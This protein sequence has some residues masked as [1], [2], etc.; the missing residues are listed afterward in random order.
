MKQRSKRYY[1][2]I[3]FSRTAKY[4]IDDAIDL[5]QQ[6]VNTKFDA[7]IDI[8]INFDNNIKKTNQNVIGTVIL[9]HGTGKQIK[10]L[11]LTK[12]KIREAQQAGADFVGAEEL[13]DQIQNENWLDFNTIIATP[14]IMKEISKISKILGPKGLMPNVKTNTITVDIVKTINDIRTGRIVYKLDKT[15]NIHC[16]IGKV[17][18][19]KQFLCDNFIALIDEI[20]YLKSNIKNIVVCP[21]M[22]PS[23]K[24]NI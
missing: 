3:I 2:N 17:S 19:N 5:V 15:N 14:D 24:I 7:A 12:T 1:N 23:I 18:F 6:M 16:S 4:D 13:I 21:T 10:I 22:G 11:V 20:S 8:H 9:P